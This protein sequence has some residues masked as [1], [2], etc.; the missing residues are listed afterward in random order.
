M[1]NLFRFPCPNCG[2]RLKAKPES[3]GHSAHCIKCGARFNVPDPGTPKYDSLAPLGP[4]EAANA[5]TENDPLPTVPKDEISDDVPPLVLTV[6][7]RSTPLVIAQ[8]SYNRGRALGRAILFLVPI[9]GCLF[10]IIGLAMYGDANKGSKSRNVPVETGPVGGSIEPSF[11][12]AP[13]PS[14]HGDLAVFAVPCRDRAVFVG[15]LSEHRSDQEYLGV[16]VSVFNSN[17]ARKFDYV[18]WD[19]PGSTATLKDDLGNRYILMRPPLGF[20]YPQLPSAPSLVS[21][22]PLS[23]WL[24]F[25]LPVPAAQ[26]LLLD[27]P[28]R[29]VGEKGSAV[30]RIDANNLLSVEAATAALEK[31]FRR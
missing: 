15:L 20:R 21:G 16:H 31:S 27:L 1:D 17:P 26:R 10:A 7:H 28:L 29:N 18:T 24:W 25:E 8:E 4:P 19:T 13:G 22:K 2:K 6:R 14:M 12:D 11:V 9:C 3:V 23:N 30:F 5:T